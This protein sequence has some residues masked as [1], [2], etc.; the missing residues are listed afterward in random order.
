MQET[1]NPYQEIILKAAQDEA[2]REALLRD[3]KATL[4]AHLGLQLP[5]EFKV[6]VVENTPSE[7][8]LV[9]PPKLRDALSDDELDQVAGG[10][11]PTAFLDSMFSIM[12]LGAGCLVSA[13][14]GKGD[15]GYCREQLVQDRP[16]K[17]P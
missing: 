10:I 17:R 13:I 8:T 4:E 6:N 1:S 9:I 15:I 2:F 16:R 5:G 14:S 12:T 7:L 3:P 11:N